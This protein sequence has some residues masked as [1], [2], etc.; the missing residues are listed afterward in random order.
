MMHVDGL[1]LLLP[2]GGSAQQSAHMFYELRSLG[3][4]LA[5]GWRC[6]PLA[7]GDA[8]IYS[9]LLDAAGGDGTS[10]TDEELA[11]FQAWRRAAKVLWASDSDWRSRRYP[12]AISTAAGILFS[13]GCRRPLSCEM[14]KVTLGQTTTRPTPQQPTARIRLS[15][16]MALLVTRRTEITLSAHPAQ[17][18]QLRTFSTKL[19]AH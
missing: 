7:C 12:S 16:L 3:Y 19:T 8:T 17:P 5:V 11:S 15:R 18:T 9:A 6:E 14:F 13:A 4:S 2:L 10:M 1:K